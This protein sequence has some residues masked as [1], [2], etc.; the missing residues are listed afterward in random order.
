MAQRYRHRRKSKAAK[1]ILSS[2][3]KYIPLAAFES[4]FLGNALDNINAQPDLMGK[5]KALVNAHTGKV[6]GLNLFSDAPK[7]GVKI[8]FSN[9]GNPLTVAGV[10]LMV[11]GIIGKKFNI[12]YTGRLKSLGA[13]IAV[14]AAI[15]SMFEGDVGVGAITNVALT[16]NSS[17][18]SI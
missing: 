15:G 13:K 18:S 10:S 14:P 12:P 5:L 9:I 17:G 7:F 4:T 8:G 6:L 2:V 16:T 11:A 1:G 3:S